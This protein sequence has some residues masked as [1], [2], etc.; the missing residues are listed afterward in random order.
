M[1]SVS[2]CQSRS[3]AL[4]MEP[5]RTEELLYLPPYPPLSVSTPIP[6]FLPPCLTTCHPHYNSKKEDSRAAARTTADS[7]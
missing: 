4:V 2:H 1:R 3:Q 5:N 7:E 6:P